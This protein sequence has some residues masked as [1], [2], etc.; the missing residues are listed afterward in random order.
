MFGTRGGLNRLLPHNV[1][2]IM[3]DLMPNN[4]GAT[5]FRKTGC[6]RA[7]AHHPCD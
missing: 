5:I 6:R 7:P 1:V 4:N 2:A 3:V